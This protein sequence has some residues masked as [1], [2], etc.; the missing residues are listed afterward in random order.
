[1]EIPVLKSPISEIKYPLERYNSRF[2]Q[3]EEIIR[4][5]EDRA[6]EIHQSE[7][8]KEKIKKK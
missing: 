7:D 2:E 3:A 4:V 6:I 5:L 8:E 1:M